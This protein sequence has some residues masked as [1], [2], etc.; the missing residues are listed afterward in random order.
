MIDRQE[1]LTNSIEVQKNNFK[2]ILE[3]KNVEVSEEENKLSI[4]IQKVGELKE[5]DGIAWLYKNG[6]EYSTITGGWNF[7]DT[8]TGGGTSIEG[9]KN[10]DHLYV[11]TVY[12]C[13][14][15]IADTIDF[16]NYSKL[17]VEYEITK[18]SDTAM[19]R[20]AVKD[21]YPYNTTV[22]AISTTSAV[23]RDILEVN[24]SSVSGVHKLSCESYTGTNSSSQFNF[25]IYKIWL[26]K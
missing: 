1:L 13:A 25:K 8:W 21:D 11:S 3:S 5:D 26:E 19:L 7:V 6:N 14:G 12:D 23:K 4:L 15:F 2:S 17:K 24:V 20:V 9:I 10:S 22:L 16:T 18:N